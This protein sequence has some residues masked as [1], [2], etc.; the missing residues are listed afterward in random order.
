MKCRACFAIA[1]L[2]PIA[3]WASGC[4]G[5]EPTAI[6][7]QE[8][9]SL[10]QEQRAMPPELKEAT[11]TP[12]PTPEPSQPT[13]PPETEQVMRL[14]VED[15]AERLDL[16]PAEIRLVSV[17]AVDWPDTSLGCP[18]PG[19]M[20]AQVITPG[21]R[22][23]LKAEGQEYEYHTDMDRFAVLCEEGGET[24]GG[25]GVESVSGEPVTPDPQSPYYSLVLK[26]VED[27]AGR[28][29]VDVGEI[30][31]LEVQEAIWPDSSLGCPQPGMAYKQV[32]ED[33]L[34][35]RLDVGGQLYEY[36]SSGMRDPFLCEQTIKVK[37]PAIKF[38]L[39]K[40]IP[41]PVDAG[42]Q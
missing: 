9:L 3:A 27:L 28:L 16:P 32:P 21:Y 33:G 40:T 8:E 2:L 17:E 34:L 41:P 38:D 26:A 4:G 31:V 37:P 20:Y 10:A 30:G 18:Q 12:I 15:L 35:I 23:V 24:P 13:P 11:M 14:A 22:V 5:G 39:T 7:P 25:A 1:L 6:A 42:D 29:S 19:M 36:H